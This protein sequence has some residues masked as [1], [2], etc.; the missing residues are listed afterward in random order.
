MLYFSNHDQDSFQIHQTIIFYF[1]Y[2]YFRTWKF[3]LNL[4]FLKKKKFTWIASASIILVSRVNGKY[5]T[6]N[7]YTKTPKLHYK[8]KNKCEWFDQEQQQQQQLTIST[9]QSYERSSSPNNISGAMYMGVP[10]NDE[11]LRALSVSVLAR[12]K[13]A[14]RTFE[15]SASTNSTFSAFTS[16]CA[17][18][19][20]CK[21]ASALHSCLVMCDASYSRQQNGKEIQKKVLNFSSQN[22]TNIFSI[23][24]HT[25]SLNASALTRRA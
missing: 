8:T 24:F 22:H 9:L 20:P 10:T 4:Y 2:C 13:S 21:Y 25:F 1:Y 14:R 23:L 7:S 15:P 16:R 6:N 17:V 12:P 5:P 3:E 18:P 19:R 11:N